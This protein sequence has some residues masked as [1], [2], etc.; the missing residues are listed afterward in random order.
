MT[1]QEAISI[2]RIHQQWRLGADISMV[3]PKE[4]TEAINILLD[5]TPQVTDEDVHKL[6]NED[7][8]KL[9]YKELT[10]EE[11]VRWFVNHYYETGMEYRSMYE[12]MKNEDLD[13]FVWY[14]EKVEIPKFYRVK[15]PYTEEQVE[16]ENIE[17][18]RQTVVTFLINELLQNRLFA[19]RYDAD[20]IFNEIVEK[21]N[22]M[23]KQEII[24]AFFEGAYGGDNISG[25]QYYQET[26][27]NKGSGVLTDGSGVVSNISGAVELPQQETLYTEEQV[28]FIVEKSRETGLTA[29]YLMLSLKQPK[30]DE[31]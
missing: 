22:E 15:N 27:G 1:L 25:E 20:N 28:K 6:G 19:L 30:R 26:F 29:E 16:D 8:P 9:G 31:L 4:L 14:G 3:E 10:Y 11:R 12:Y 5:N 13:N 17:K 7:V 23:H 2:L 21:A 24:D 18:G